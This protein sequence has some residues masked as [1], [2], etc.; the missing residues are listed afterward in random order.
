MGLLWTAPLFL[1]AGVWFGIFPAL[2]VIGIALSTSS[3]PDIDQRI[4]MISH[5]G[6]T[7]TVWFAIAIASIASF[8]VGGFLTYFVDYP[9][10]NQI[11]SGPLRSQGSVGLPLLGTVLA[12]LT[13]FISVCSHLAADGLTVGKG[14][15][16]IKPFWPISSWPLYFGITRFDSILWNYGLFLGGVATQGLCIAFILQNDWSL[17]AAVG[18]VAGLSIA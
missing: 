15:H 10:L 4:A 6:S 1:L 8:V 3:L 12:F 16:L 7:H 14:N 18:S 5:R 2:L 17:L 11:F 13:A 9:L